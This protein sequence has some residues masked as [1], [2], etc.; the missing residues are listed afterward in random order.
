[1]IYELEFQEQNTLNSQRA[2]AKT[3]QKDLLMKL[4]K[5]AETLATIDS[6]DKIKDAKEGGDKSN[7]V[8]ENGSIALKVP[9]QRYE[10]KHVTTESPEPKDAPLRS[11]EQLL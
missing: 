8:R 1:M 7:V 5:D 10:V 9:K 2:E 4:L 11:K 6:T 3:Q